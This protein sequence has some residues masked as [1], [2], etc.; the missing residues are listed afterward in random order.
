[1]IYCQQINYDGIKKIPLS[2]ILKPAK[3]Q[4]IIRN[5]QKFKNE[6]AIY[7]PMYGKDML[8]DFFVFWTELTI[9]KT[10]MRFETEKTWQFDLRLL[11]WSKSQR[12]NENRGG[13]TSNYI[14]N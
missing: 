14:S 2:V 11:R 13:A 6:L 8:N 9:S 3:S 1:M 12:K 7:L 5:K 10:K 4:I